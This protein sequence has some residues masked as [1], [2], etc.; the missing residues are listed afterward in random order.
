[1]TDSTARSSRRAFL[2]QG[3]AVLGAGV[4][5]TAGAT[6][7]PSDGTVPR[8]DE[9]VRLKRQVADAQDREAIR[10]LQRTFLSTPVLPQALVESYH[11]AYRPDTRR[12]DALLLSEDGLQA[13]CVMHVEAEVCTPLRG[14]STIAA[15]ARLQGNVAAS[16]WEAGRLDITYI[17]TAGVWQTATLAY[18]SHHTDGDSQ[19]E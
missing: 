7:L 6:A 16:R 13:S 4:A 8:Q 17:K 14:N 2:T 11:R 10:Q 18:T 1:M 3:S 12:L 5:A 19:H 9:L 15:M